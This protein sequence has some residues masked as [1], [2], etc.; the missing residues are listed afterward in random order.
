MVISNLAILQ[1]QSGN[2]LGI[3]FRDSIKSKI[4]NNEDS[5]CNFAI[6]NFHSHEYTGEFSR[7]YNIKMQKQMKNQLSNVQSGINE[8]CKD[9][10]QCHFFS[11]KFLV[12]ENMAI[13]INKSHLH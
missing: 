2:L 1:A 8:I 13:F 6:C 7:S 4:F 5:I 12:L 9:V 3:L 11:L 10:K